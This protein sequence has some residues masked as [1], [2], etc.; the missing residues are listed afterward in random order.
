IKMRE[1]RAIEA[2][3]P[4]LV[5]PSSPTQRVSGEARAGVIKVKHEHRMFSLDNAYSET[6]MAEFARR[7]RDGLPDA[8]TPRFVGEPKLDGASVEVVYQ[9]GVLFLACTRGDGETGED[10]TH[11]MRT[12]RGV[13]LKIEDKRKLTLRG[14]VVILRKHFEEMNAERAAEGLEPFANPRNTAAGSIRM[15]DPREVEK[16]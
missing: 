7:I 3:H 11:N 14:E 1:L 13:P 10:V 12:V 8:E 4:D 9:A 2:E 16:R 15:L 6:E 5:T